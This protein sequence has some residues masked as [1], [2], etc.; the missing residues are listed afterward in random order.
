MTFIRFKLF[1]YIL[2]GV[3]EHIG[4]EGRRSDGRGLR[5]RLRQEQRREETSQCDCTFLIELE[6]APLHM[7]LPVRRFWKVP[8]HNALAL[9]FPRREGRKSRHLCTISHDLLKKEKANI[10]KSRMTFGN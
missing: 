5:G 10:D 1:S 7:C 6:L 8:S 4:S 3:A 2:R 9:V